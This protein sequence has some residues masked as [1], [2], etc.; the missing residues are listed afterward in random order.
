M[1]RYL[2]VCSWGRTPSWPDRCGHEVT[3]ARVVSKWFSRRTK[4]LRQVCCFFL[5]PIAMGNNLS[6]STLP[7]IEVRQGTEASHQAPERPVPQSP[8]RPGTPGSEGSVQRDS[9]QN[10]ASLG[11][12]ARWP[13]RQVD[14][15]D[16]VDLNAEVRSTSEISA[17][18][19]FVGQP[20]S[21]TERQAGPRPSASRCSLRLKRRLTYSRVG[22][23]SGLGL[24][25]Q[26]QYVQ[27]VQQEQ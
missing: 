25:R 19:C 15:A 20:S 2:P 23:G 17:R 7:T 11:V 14:E 18:S 16:S 12:A 10:G 13:P 9:E 22:V 24:T 1:S 6:S 26:Y 8:E 3:A 27:S 4:L 21:S 5:P